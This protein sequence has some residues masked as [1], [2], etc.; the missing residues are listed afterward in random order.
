MVAE[1]QDPASQTSDPAVPQ[2][3]GGT[4]S[5]TDAESI[6]GD[7]EGVTQAAPETEAVGAEQT[8][9]ESEADPFAD[10][11][12]EAIEAQ[13][14]AK[15]EQLTAVKLE[16]AEN[17]RKTKEET[18]RKW[19]EQAGIQQAFAQRAPRLRQF[20]TEQGLEQQAVDLVLNEFTAQYNHSQPVAQRQALDNYSQLQRE[21]MLS[22]LPESARESF[23]KKW[24][25]GEFQDGE[26]VFKEFLSLGRSNYAPK[27]EIEAAKKTAK[28]EFI[29][30]LAE[31][32]E[33]RLAQLSSRLRAPNPALG[34][35]GAGVGGLPTL[36]QW[37]GATYEQR[38][39]WETQFG[40]D[41]A[42]KIV[43]RGR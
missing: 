3:Q 29:Q 17:D 23:A 15:A 32:P 30:W 37:S 12:K 11:S 19:R 5:A 10:L 25:G 35:G 2:D 6:L 27:S 40:A 22:A 16:Q 34:N 41:V 18:E 14:T 8:P 28:V 26:S 21:A 31:D 4:E 13:A 1:L 36:Q 42:D 33:T 9:A 39:G 43:A 38:R 24:D 7:L 20:L